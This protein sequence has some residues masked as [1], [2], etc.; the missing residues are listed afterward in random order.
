MSG[1][2]TSGCARKY[3]IAPTVCARVMLSGVL[4]VVLPG[5]DSTLSPVAS[6]VDAA[7]CP[8]RSSAVSPMISVVLQLVPASER[9][10]G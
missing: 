5:G 9:C 2:Y 10:R 4:S 6:P 7:G 3:T 1:S 8:V